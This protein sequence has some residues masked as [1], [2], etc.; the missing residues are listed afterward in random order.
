M[1]GIGGRTQLPI[2]N[3]NAVA[4]RVNWLCG[5]TCASRA[6]KSRAGKLLVSRFARAKLVPGAEYSI[7]MMDSA[8]PLTRAVLEGYLRCRYLGALRLAG[9]H[10]D[11]SEY[12]TAREERQR[13]VR[14]ALTNRADHA[15]ILVA[16]GMPLSRD[17]LRRGDELILDA[18]LIGDDIAMDYPGLQRVRGGSALGHF[19]YMPIILGGGWHSR[20]M[21]RS[22]VEVLAV[23]LEDMQGVLPAYGIV[24]CGPDCKAV[25]V[26]FSADR[27]VGKECRS[28]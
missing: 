26:K 27:R 2:C 23:M 24:Y 3:H 19:H 8:S 21:D 17:A 5:G 16:H 7:N 18:R 15:G 28:R 22:V 9:E 1:R 10:G 20:R 4:R 25:K 12:F 14:T 6:G 13:L 11:S